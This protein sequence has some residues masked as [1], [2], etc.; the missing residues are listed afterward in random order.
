[1]KYPTLLQEYL[2]SARKGGELGRT[3]GLPY[4]FRFFLHRQNGTETEQEDQDGGHS[5]AG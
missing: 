4:R 2:A 3:A 5:I 1:M